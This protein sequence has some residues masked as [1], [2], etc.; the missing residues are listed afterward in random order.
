MSFSRMKMILEKNTDL[1][2]KLKDIRNGNYGN[3]VCRHI[4]FFLY[5]LNCFKGKYTLYKGNSK[6]LWGLG[7]MLTVYK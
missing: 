2:K 1:Y 4:R 7:Y 3:Y 5:Y 6:I